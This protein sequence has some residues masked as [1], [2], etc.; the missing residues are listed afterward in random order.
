MRR[1]WLAVWLAA[2]MV[3]ASLHPAGATPPAFVTGKHLVQVREGASLDEAEGEIQR[4]GGR[5]VDRV[6][7]VRMLVVELPPGAA[8][9]SQAA[10][11]HSPRFESFEPEGLYEPTFVPNDPLIPSEWHLSKV[12]AFGA[13]DLVQGGLAPV[14]ILDSGIDPSHPDLAARLV[15][16]WNCYDNNA[17]T[18]DVYGHGTMVAGSAAAAGNNGIGVAGLAFTSPIM[19]M[20]VTGTD[21]W[22]SGSAIVKALTWA[23]DHGARVAN[24]SFGGIHS[25]SSILAGAQYFMSKGGLVTASAGNYNTDDGS[26]DTP[27]VVSVSATAGDDTKAS[28]S[29][30][31]RYV[32]VA[33][34]GVGIYTTTR[35]GGWAGASGT[36]FSAP[37]T[38][39]VIAL[40]LAAKPTLTPQQAE[41]ILE[42]NADDLGAPGFDT[43]YGWGRVNALR[44]V[45]AALA[46]AAPPPDASAPTASIS[47]PASGATVSGSVAISASA[48]DNVG[49]TEVRFYVD[50]QMIASDVAAPFS[51]AWNSATAGNGAHA[52]AA[53]AYDAAGNR[54]S[55]PTV[56]VMVSNPVVA[57]TTPPSVSITAPAGGATVGMKQTFTANASDA[58]GIARVEFFLD[59]AWKTTDTTAP[60]TFSVMT[61]KWTPGT[62]T[63]S[64]RAVDG[65]GLSATASVTVVK[66]QS[67]KGAKKH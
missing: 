39:G 58:S 52:V 34:P 46:A 21:G 24:L 11:E 4:H 48:S 27:Y 41:G 45:T 7:E 26:L 28:W 63:V 32:D 10:L 64:A 14:A 8:Q 31:G 51:A 43:I 6:D 19:P 29:S 65:A 17:D 1:A 53:D 18:S 50:G 20:R 61:K 33:A 25:A 3:G 38:A 5:V 23:A 36:S 47:S 56:S 62:H 42:A 57:D 40:V 13:W 30:F 54:G 49:V 67:L 22:A 66:P 9:A 44:A 37:V 16:G 35:G 12:Q 2:G 59:G 15:P 55:A 60:W